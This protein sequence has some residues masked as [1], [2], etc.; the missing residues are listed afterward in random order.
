MDRDKPAAAGGAYTARKHVLL[1]RVMEVSLRLLSVRERGT[2]MTFAE[3]VFTALC[4]LV[5][6]QSGGRQCERVG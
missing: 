4:S 5:V 6:S 2:V 1:K 3:W